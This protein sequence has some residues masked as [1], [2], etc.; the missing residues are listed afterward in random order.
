MYIDD[1]CCS[2]IDIIRQHVL[3]GIAC[4]RSVTASRSVT[5][6]N[7]AGH[8][9]TLTRQQPS[10]SQLSHLSP[11]A[12]A[13]ALSRGSDADTGGSGLTVEGARSSQSDVMASNGVLHI[14]DSVLFHSSGDPSF[15]DRR[16][17]HFSHVSLRF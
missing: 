16:S 1:V 9:I 12:A 6:R 13:A 3:A 7:V 10:S 5:L 11:A 2:S 15:F 14:I 8:Y 17:L 4:S